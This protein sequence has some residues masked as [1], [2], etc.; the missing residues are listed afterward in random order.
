LSEYYLWCDHRSWKEAALYAAIE[1]TTFHTRVILERVEE[2]GV[3][4]RRVINAGGIP[5]RSEVLNRM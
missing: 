4:V 3:P 1:G 2:H 5:Q